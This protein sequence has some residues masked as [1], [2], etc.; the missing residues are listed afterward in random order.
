MSDRLA[1]LKKV[2]IKYN[3]L[4]ERKKVYSFFDQI[5]LKEREVAFK[6]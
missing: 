5:K 6:K 2:E 4:I 3:E 1:L